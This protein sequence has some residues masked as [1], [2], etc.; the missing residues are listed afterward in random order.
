MDR[1]VFRILWALMATGGAIAT[2]F[3]WYHLTED[4]RSLDTTLGQ[5]IARPIEILNDVQR[6]AKTRVIWQNI[7]PYE[8]LYSGEEIRT[9]ENS[10]VK[11][12]LLHN[13]TTIHLEPDSLVVLQE[14][15]GQVELDFLHGNLFIKSADDP[16][17]RLDKAELI[18]KS[19]NSKIDLAKTDLALS[20][21]VKGNLEVQVLKGQANVQTGNKSVTIAQDHVGV[22]SESGVRV[23]YDTLTVIS[24]VSGKTIYIHPTAPEPIEVR[25]KKISPQYNLA[26]ELGASRTRMQILNQAPVKGHVGSLKIPLKAGTFYWRLSAVHPD[27]KLPSL[28]SLVHRVNVLPMIPPLTVAPGNNEI[29]IRYPD[30]DPTVHFKWANPSGFSSI[31]LEIAQDK[32]LKKS[33][34]KNTFQDELAY[35]LRDLGPGNY[36]WRLTGYLPSQEFISSVVQSFSVTHQEILGVPR[37]VAPLDQQTLHFSK[38]QDS[39]VYLEWKEATGAKQYRI[40]MDRVYRLAQRKPSSV[41]LGV[42]PGEP[43]DGSGEVVSETVI[44]ERIPMNHY[45]FLGFQPGV[46]RWSVRSIGRRDQ[47]SDSSLPRHFLIKGTE[48]LNWGRDTASPYYYSTDRPTLFLSWDHSQQLSSQWRLRWAAGNELNEVA[49][50]INLSRSQELLTLPIPG[51][52]TVQVQALSSKGAPL[53]ATSMR[54]FQVLPLP[55]L[56]APEFSEKIKLLNPITAEKNGSLALEWLMVVGAKAYIV[57]IRN[58]EGFLLEQMKFNQT[59]ARVSKLRPGSY[60][61]VLRSVDEQNRVGKPGDTKQLL[62]PSIS[63]VRAPSLKGIKVD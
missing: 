15:P 33:L 51:P 28:K 42:M 18:I 53:A 20:K 24:P 7:G 49:H 38:V 23:N 55:S 3:I 12:S 13:G 32:Q 62:V 50:E 56:P 8:N 21:K 36:F 27:P 61:L 60:Q 5:P 37:L 52:Y 31:V 47:I 34:V 4:H 14:A 46:Y 26:V 10:E 43:P 30:E 19:G 6:K 40:K 22:V 58:S 39:G 57:E 54:T 17:R 11:I 16:N 63:D 2:T 45:R 1:F 25:W 29:L 35:D 59:Q 9:S 48:Q 44:E 41:H